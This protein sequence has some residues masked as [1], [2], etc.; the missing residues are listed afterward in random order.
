MQA[1]LQTVGFPESGEP[2][3]VLTVYKG[4]YNDDGVTVRLG[5]SE[6]ALD[7]Y[8]EENATGYRMLP[9]T[10]CTFDTRS[11]ELGA[12]RWKANVTVTFRA[13]ELPRGTSLGQRME[14]CPSPSPAS[15]QAK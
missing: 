4:G 14:S 15:H 8:N 1:G 13:S 2:Q 11:V 3:A 5:I 10:Y 9:E 7:R 6:Y 12:K